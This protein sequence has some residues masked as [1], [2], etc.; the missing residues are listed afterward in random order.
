[1]A[2]LP[3]GN[4]IR[5]L[6]CSVNSQKFTF[7]RVTKIESSSSSN[8]QI[9][10]SLVCDGYFWFLLYC[11]CVNADAVSA[12]DRI[13]GPLSDTLGDMSSDP[14]ENYSIHSVI[15]ACSMLLF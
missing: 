1:M 11:C 7:G 12:E 2:L 10:G 14:G 15:V 4:C 13:D 5:P 6:F 9:N 3:E 8:S